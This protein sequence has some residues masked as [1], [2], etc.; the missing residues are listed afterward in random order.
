MYRRL[1][2]V[3]DRTKTWKAW[4]FES[5]CRRAGD[6]H[7][8]PQNEIFTFA[9]EV[10]TTSLHFC[11]IAALEK[12]VQELRIFR[13]CRR[14]HIRSPRKKSTTIHAI[15]TEDEPNEAQRDEDTL[16]RLSAEL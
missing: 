14:P 5:S 10:H 3:A 4:L 12:T 6:Q 15:V 8:S 2:L 13:G 7:P 1:I 16:A 11:M 9:K